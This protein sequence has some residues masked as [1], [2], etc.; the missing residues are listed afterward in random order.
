MAHIL[1]VEHD[2]DIRRVMTIMLE[3]MGH[4]ITSLTRGERALECAC[5]I[6]PDLIILDVSPPRLDGAAVAAQ[7]RAD[8]QI[9]ETPILAATTHAIYA[10]PRIRRQAGFDSVLVKPFSMTDLR[11]AVNALLRA[12]RPASVA[13]DAAA[14]GLLGA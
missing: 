14:L 6:R 12:E 7:L 13:R 11:V 5:Q 3:R 2:E 9:Q 4:A 10:N 8:S 1:L